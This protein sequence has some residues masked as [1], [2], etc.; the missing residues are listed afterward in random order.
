M[1]NRKKRFVASRAEILQKL[2]VVLKAACAAFE[3]GQEHKAMESIF[4]AA[5][6]DGK[7]RTV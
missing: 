7:T 1:D 3:M 5:A 6:S 4:R 2:P